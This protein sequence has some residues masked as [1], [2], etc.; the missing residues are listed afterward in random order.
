MSWKSHRLT[1]TIIVD[2]E[3]LVRLTPVPKHN[4]FKPCN[5]KL[6]TLALKGIKEVSFKICLIKLQHFRHQIGS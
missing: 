6:L 3:G 2:E 5:Q 1:E 4:N